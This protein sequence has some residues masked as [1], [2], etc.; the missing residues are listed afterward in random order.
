MSELQLYLLAIGAVLIFAVYLFNRYQERG[1]RRK[2]EQAFPKDQDDVLLMNAQ[3]DADDRRE[4]HARQE[5][6]GLSEPDERREPK[7]N[8]GVPRSESGAGERVEPVLSSAPELP[9]EPPIATVAEEKKEPAPFNGYPGLD[10][11]IHYIAVIHP[12]RALSGS[13]LNGVVGRSGDI[14]K[15]VVWAGL[16]SANGEWEEILAG[17]SYSE[18]KAG[19]QLSNRAGPASEQQLEAFSDLIEDS[20]AE[21]GATVE[22]PELDRSLAVARQLDEFCARVDVMIGLNIVS[23]NGA[24]F[25]GTKVRTLAESSGFKLNP[26]GAFEYPTDHGVPLFYLANQESQPFVADRIKHLTT[27]GVT[28]LFDVPRVVEGLRAFDR[29]VSLAK[30]FTE[31][32]GGTFVDDNGRPLNDESIGKIREQLREI[33]RVM[34]ASEIP[35]GSAR[36]L[37]LFS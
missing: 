27:R 25:H 36:A 16:N 29:M 17:A 31:I 9:R 21:W 4:P 2:S 28:L 10:A 18:V 26:A 35:P 32:L 1:Y 23:A 33:Y 12:N 7:F 24:P 3:H 37:K 15:P 8:D 14:G 20:A 5:P 30:R 13:D 6:D 22:C 11:T 19:L 34:E